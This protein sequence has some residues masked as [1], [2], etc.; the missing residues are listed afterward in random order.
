LTGI[1]LGIAAG[2]YNFFRAVTGLTK[3]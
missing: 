1:L 2:F 3:G